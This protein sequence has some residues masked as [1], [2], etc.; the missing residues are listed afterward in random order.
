MIE[1]YN[2]TT[3]TLLPLSVGTTVLVQDSISKR[4]NK[5]G[6]IVDFE[7]RKYMIRMDGSGRVVSRNRKF[8]KPIHSDIDQDVSAE[9]FDPTPHHSDNQFTNQFD[10]SEGNITTTTDQP[11]QSS[12]SIQCSSTSND[13]VITEAPRGNYNARIPR[14]L[15]RLNPH[16]KPGLK[17]L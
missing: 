9:L 5:L 3:R 4:W 17:E 6:S 2:R 11:N 12:R 8:I 10:S 1:R 16:N 15:S 13:G 14:A 7:G